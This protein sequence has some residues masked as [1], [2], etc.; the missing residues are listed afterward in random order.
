MTPARLRGPQTFRTVE[1]GRGLAALLVVLFHTGSAIFP[2]PKYWNTHVFGRAFDWGYAGVFF[3]FVLSGFIIVH[4]H[5]SDVG[6]P[7]RL[8][9]YLTKRAVRIYPLYWLVLAGIV[10]LGTA[11]VGE[12]PEVGTILSSVVL[13]GPDNKATVVAVAWTLYHEV[14]FYA[15]FAAWIASARLGL[16]VTAIW[17][18]MIAAGLVLKLPVPD[19]VCAPV[20]LLFVYGVLTWR[21]SQLR[22]PGASLIAASAAVAFVAVGA[23]A[24][25]WQRLSEPVHE[26][27]FGL[28]AAIGLAATVSI[29][30]RRAVAVPRPLLLLGAAS[31][32]IYLTH[33]PI[34]SLLAKLSVRFGIVARVPAEIAFIGVV[35]LTVAAGIA[36][37]RLVERP[38]LAAIN[39]RAFARRD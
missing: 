11:G 3:F 21:L 36:V 35:V 20:N 24:V 7:G 13:A 14:L 6:Q 10:A 8:R 38:L 18:A 26:Q 32:S 4:V 30:R 25:W 29:E 28:A 9:R 31:Y 5:A 12:V 39:T 16:A 37:H 22:I 17:S 34:L 1:A 27:F 33:F 2:A 19:Y 15:V 23:D